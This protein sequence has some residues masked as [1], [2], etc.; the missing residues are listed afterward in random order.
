M[1]CCFFGTNNIGSNK[2]APDYFFP[3]LPDRHS[4][5]NGCFNPQA[6]NHKS[7][8]ETPQWISM[9]QTSGWIVDVKGPLAQTQETPTASFLKVEHASGLFLTY[10]IYSFPTPSGCRLVRCEFWSGNSEGILMLVGWSLNIFINIMGP[11]VS[12]TSVFF[13]FMLLIVCNPK[14]R[15][16][17]RIEWETWWNC[18][19]QIFHRGDVNLSMMPGEAQSV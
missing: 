10:I 13:L 16:S 5:I 18:S 12:F 7:R 1:L 14:T 8:I 6:G 19:E 4:F 17:Y 2:T 15:K 3:Q 11:D 9:H